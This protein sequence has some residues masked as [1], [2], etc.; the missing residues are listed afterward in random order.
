MCIF[1]SFD[2]VACQRDGS[3]DEKRDENAAAAV[4]AVDV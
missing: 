2:Y 3:D 1:I 4:A